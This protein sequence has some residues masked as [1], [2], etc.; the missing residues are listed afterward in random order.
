MST[1]LPDPTDFASDA[2][3]GLDEEFSDRSG[4]VTTQLDR[5]EVVLTWKP[6]GK[7]SKRVE[8]I[9]FDT[10]TRLVRIFPRSIK[11]DQLQHQ[12]AQIRELWVAAA[13]WDPSNHS[14]KSDR[15][16]LFRVVGL[17]P[18]FNVFYAYGLGIHRHYKDFIK[19][20]EANSAGYTIVSFTSDGTEGPSE[21]G[22]VFRVSL[23]RFEQY[24]AAVD[25]NKARGRVAADRVNEAE[26]HNS[27]AEIV[28]LPTM[29][30]KYGRN[31]IIRRLTEE[32]ETGYVLNAADRDTLIDQVSAAA[33]SVA[34]EA[35]QKFGQL[36]ADIE[37]V[38]LETLVDQFEHALAGPHAKK[39]AY[40]QSFFDT[41]RFALQQLFSMP[42]V[43]LATQAHLRGADLEGRGA[44]I[45]DF[46]CANTVTRTAVVVEI[47]TP[48][49]PIMEPGSYRGSNES[50]VHA[51]HKDLSGTIAQ[52]QSQMAAI[53][54]DLTPQRLGRTSEIDLDLWNDIRGA[55]IVGRLS[56]LSPSQHE[57]FIR[58]RSAL[59]TVT[60]LGYDEV[61]ERLR[62]L[63]EMLQNASADSVEISG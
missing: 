52:L 15:F 54:Q 19:T 28:G 13:D 44:R 14:E 61:L 12:F 55:I 43:T 45:A 62:G 7:K 48:G 4:S 53:P 9:R 26:C 17:P 10:R 50:G 42:I 47:K 18:G 60:I 31:E 37:L 30:V 2:I 21:D 16:D 3:F 33:Q 1:G 32:V 34:L 49:A 5:D 24:R 36:R 39:E 63:L 22:R 27:L 20:I 6:A 58:Y 11:H 46:L 56:S 40:W 8:M 41:N 38:S 51:L 25:R 29:E 23:K 35:P 57:S 59:S